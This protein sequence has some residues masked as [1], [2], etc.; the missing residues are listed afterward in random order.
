MFSVVVSGIVEPVGGGGGAWGRQ[1]TFRRW[2]RRFEV[3]AMRGRSGVWAS[4]RPSGSGGRGDAGRS[5]LPRA[6]GFHGQALPRA[7]GEGPRLPLGLHLDQDVFPRPRPG[8]AG[9]ARGA[10]AQAAA[11][12]AR[13]HDAASGRLDAP[14]APGRDEEQDMIVSLDDASGAIYSGFLV[15]GGHHVASRGRGEVFG[16]HGLPCAL[17][18]DRASHYFHTP[19]AGGKV[20][21]DKPS[22]LGRALAQLRHR[23]HR[24]LF[25]GGARALRAR[26]RTLQDRLR[27]WHWPA[28]RRSKG[29]TA[30]SPRPSFPTT[31]RA[32]RSLPKSR[33]RPSSWRDVLCVQETRTVGNDNTVRFHGIVLQIPPS[34]LRPHY[35][36]APRPPLSGR[37][38]RHI[39]RAAPDAR[40]RGDGALLEGDTMKRAA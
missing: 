9:A 7:P 2:C 20:D 13:G 3:R 23:A 30:S 10:P 15:A 25:A 21:R 33:A 39:P 19:Q 22:Q 27:S 14:L 24:G 18:T 26:L 4:R 36:K 17:Y 1:R 32:S 37:H 34:S 29:P 6:R 40:Y 35:V 28:S 5:S 11:A 12:A 16:R 8:G 38:L 31:M